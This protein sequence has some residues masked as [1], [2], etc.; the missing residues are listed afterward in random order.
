[1]Y[2]STPNLGLKKPELTDNYSLALLNENTDK[3]DA[4]F[5]SVNATSL[6][7]ANKDYFVNYSDTQAL[8]WKSNRTYAKDVII[9]HE[10]QLYISLI[11]SNTGNN[12]ATANSTAW[13]ILNITPGGTETANLVSYNKTSSGLSSSNI[14]NAID[15]LNQNIIDL[16]L[17]STVG[18]GKTTTFNADGSITEQIKDSS[19]TVLYYKNT[20]FNE[21][22]SIT[23]TTHKG[24]KPI[25]K[26]TVF[27]ADGSITE[28]VTESTTS[29]TPPS[30]DSS[31]GD[32]SSSSSS[33]NSSTGSSSSGAGS[34]SSS[35]G[36]SSS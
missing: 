27:N 13:E 26:T 10:G 20:V 6:Q 11:N 19:G 2:P 15:E 22:G 9:N 36:D 33:G 4:A 30:T 32:E 35:S 8:I 17:T 31:S 24:N 12:P 7:G 25:V 21:D 14:Q 3:I 1:M 29:T 28:T 34:E 23:E 5:T 18:Q 16:G